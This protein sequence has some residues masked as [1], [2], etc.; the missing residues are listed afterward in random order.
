MADEL[1]VKTVSRGRGIPRT[2]DGSRWT[3]T[4]R[5]ERIHEVVNTAGYSVPTPAASIDA[6]GV[7]TPAGA[8][9][10][11]RL[12]EAERVKEAYRFIT[13]T[14][15]TVGS[16]DLKAD[17]LLINDKKYRVADVRPYRNDGRFCDAVA[18]LDS[19][20]GGEP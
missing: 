17:T 14:I 6:K 19:P 18:V 15:L 2:I 7:L 1:R 8:F 13:T 12:P 20:G 16:D 11:L 4:V 9:T 3:Q 5:V 10:I